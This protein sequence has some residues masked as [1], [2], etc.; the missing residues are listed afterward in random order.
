MELS[1]RRSEEQEDEITSK[2]RTRQSTCV[3]GARAH[4]DP[5]LG[6]S[7]GALNL[8]EC[9]WDQDDVLAMVVGDLT[10]IHHVSLANYRATFLPILD[11][12]S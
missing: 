6:F 7:L 1:R 8:N 4:P 10:C 5:G 3:T 2:V 9:P 11:L 12:A